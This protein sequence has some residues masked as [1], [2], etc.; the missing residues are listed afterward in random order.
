MWILLRAP[1]CPAHKVDTAPS[2]AQPYGWVFCLMQEIYLYIISRSCN[3]KNGMKGVLYKKHSVF[4]SE[5]LRKQT[6]YANLS[7]ITD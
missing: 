2:K 7:A 4:I 3:I 6:P 5:G 1:T